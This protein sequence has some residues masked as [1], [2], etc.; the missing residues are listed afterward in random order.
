MGQHS[1]GIIHGCIAPDGVDWHGEDGS[2]PDYL[3]VIGRWRKAEM[4]TRVNQSIETFPDG[5]KFMV[6]ILVAYLGEKCELLTSFAASFG[7]VK[8]E[9]LWDRFARWAEKNENLKLPAAELWIV[10]TETA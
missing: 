7:A 2:K 3:G 5:D 10:P 9:K 1:I 6:G 8:A 4:I